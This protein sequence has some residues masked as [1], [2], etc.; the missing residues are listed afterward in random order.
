MDKH[1]L[2]KSHS[3]KQIFHLTIVSI[4][5]PTYNTSLIKKT[6]NTFNFHLQMDYIEL[7]AKVH[8]HAIL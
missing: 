6:K 7:Q 2:K 4:K 8:M 3:P 5:H 1:T